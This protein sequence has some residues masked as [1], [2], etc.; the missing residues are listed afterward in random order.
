M[1]SEDRHDN[2]QEKEADA[3]RAQIRA[4]HRYVLVFPDERCSRHPDTFHAQVRE[5][6]G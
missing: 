3:I 4:G 1:V 6:C 5:L 2:A